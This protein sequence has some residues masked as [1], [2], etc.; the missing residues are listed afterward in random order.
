MIKIY[1]YLFPDELI[2]EGFNYFKKYQDWDYLA[3]SPTTNANASIGKVFTNNFE[4]IVYKFIDYLEDKV[5]GKCLYNCFNYGD[6]PKPHIDSHSKDGIT[7]LIYLNPFWQIDWAGETI[8]IGDDN[9]IITSITPKPGRL[10]KFTSNIL[11]CARPPVR[12]AIESRYSLVFQTKPV[13]DI[14]VKDLFQV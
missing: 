5:F 14:S 12:D 7:Y 11:H 1:D 10:I 3:D 4:P 6:S 2:V 13:E 8:F 9:E